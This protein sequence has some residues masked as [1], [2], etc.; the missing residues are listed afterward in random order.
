MIYNDDKALWIFWVW[1]FLG[2]TAVAFYHQFVLRAATPKALGLPL[3]K[4]I[5]LKN[6]YKS[7]L[8]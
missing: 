1:T 5:V 6:H 2:A 3:K 7:K 8:T 4:L